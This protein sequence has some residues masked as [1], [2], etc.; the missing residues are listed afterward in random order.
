MWR[1]S[2]KSEVS[3]GSS[4]PKAAL[5]LIGAVEKVEWFEARSS[6]DSIHGKSCPAFEVLHSKV[7]GRLRKIITGNVKRHVVI[8]ESLHSMKENS[9]QAYK[10]PR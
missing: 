7:A 1:T 10:L 4:S 2:L 9:Q 6:S 3:H 8:D 5:E